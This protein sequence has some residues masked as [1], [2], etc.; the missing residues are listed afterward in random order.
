MD[1]SLNVHE[2]APVLGRR[3]LGQNPR[4]G[5]RHEHNRQRAKQDVKSH[6]PESHP[7]KYCWEYSRRTEYCQE[8]SEDPRHYLSTW[9]GSGNL[10][11]S[12]WYQA[13]GE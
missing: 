4:A 13:G 11:F 2:V 3:L 9:I 6:G 8:F 12:G 1:V 5:N 10:V 7:R